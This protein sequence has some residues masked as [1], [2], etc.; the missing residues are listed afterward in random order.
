MSGSV[1]SET[2]QEI[3]STKLDELSK[4][5]AAF[6]AARTAIPKYLS[7]ELDP[8]H[9]LILVKDGVKRCFGLKTNEEASAEAG[10]RLGSSLDLT[11]S[12]AERFIS[13]ARHDPSVSE[14]IIADHEK[15]LFRELEVQSHKYRYAALYGELVTEWLAS[16]QKMGLGTIRQNEG[17]DV[18]MVDVGSAAKLKSKEEWEGKVFERADVN[19]ESLNRYLDD[20][21]ISDGA[22]GE[23]AAKEK[24]LALEKMRTAVADFE[25]ELSEPRQFRHTTLKWV[26][27]GLVASDLVSNEQREVL[28]DFRSNNVIL[29]EVADVLNMR[30]S[31]LESWNWDPSGVPIEQRRKVSGVFS[32]HIHEDLLQAI[33]LQY[34]GVKWSVFLRTTFTTFQ[35]SL[36]WSSLTDDIPLAEK[37][38]LEYY[39]GPVRQHRSLQKLRKKRYLTNYHVA[40]LLTSPI[41]A[42]KPADG[43]VEASYCLDNCDTEEE[44]EK[45]I[46]TPVA[47]K[48]QLLHLLSTE[49][50][51]NTRLSGE[52]TAFHA[53]L[54]DFETSLPHETILAVLKYLG[55]SQI[56][57]NFFLR[58]LQ[59]P[60]R[61]NDELSAPTKVQQRGVPASHV[62]SDVFGEAVLFCLDYSVNQAALGQLLWRYGEDMWFWSPDHAT[63]VTVW[64]ALENFVFIT[65]T[66]LNYQKCGAARVTG[67]GLQ[68]KPLDKALPAGQIR[69]GF[70]VLSPETGQFEVDTSMIDVHIDELRKQLMEKQ[71]SILAFIQTWNTYVGTFLTSNLG[72]PSNCF[73]QVHVDAMLAAHQHIQR[74]IFTGKGSGGF[75]ATSSIIDYLKTSITERFGIT[76]IP[77][78]YFYFP[79]DLGGL[80]LQSP[81]ISLLYKR[82]AVLDSHE[83]LIQK[84]LEAERSTYNRLKSRFEAEVPD[85][86][87]M[88]LFGRNNDSKWKPESQHDQRTFMSFEQFTQYREVL[89]IM[90]DRIG[91]P[92]DVF[93]VF[94]KLMEEPEDSALNIAS[95]GWISNALGQIQQ[96][97]HSGP[98]G[99]SW[100]AMT[101]YW[102]WI[103]KMYGP[104]IVEKFG[105]FN[106]VD[107]GLL[108]MGM[109]GLFREKRVTWKG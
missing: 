9:R 23:E 28:K 10:T 107:R 37:R 27:D 38:R 29:S 40:K 4:R 100:E 75:E 91:E 90:F 86:Q 43:E 58:F 18:E 31:A 34:I 103:A 93:S 24:R 102:Q 16:D 8:I 82:D 32:V 33:F 49:L 101:P 65:G 22:I 63:A 30:I 105:G 6:E 108:P 80:E 51:I 20:I 79:T 36:A 2:L 77:D 69:W 47:A 59:V 52:L 42:A 44:I 14:N 12:N 45:K 26:I 3:T 89:C 15:A 17:D 67:N 62:L 104:E 61:W 99:D 72:K 7:P 81:F 5:R 83:S 106:I 56:W 70:L 46:D 74:R 96:S 71:H 60:L 92:F 25:R 19:V 68:G 88:Q 39:V 50:V 53:V 94:N 13:L 55:I 41:A 98:I 87:P 54:A 76:D 48:Q 66:S 97:E 64:T 57:C 73:G 21:F 11:L 85:T 1:F 78:G 95:C 35:S 109:V 84:M